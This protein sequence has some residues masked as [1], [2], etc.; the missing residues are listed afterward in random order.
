VTYFILMGIVAG[1]AI[2]EKRYRYYA[3]LPVTPSEI[4][5]VDVLYVLLVQLPMFFLW[6]LFLLL[7]PEQATSE[8][9]WA[10]LA[11]NPIILSVAT[12]VGIHYHLGFFGTPKY[13]RVNWCLL[14]LL[15]SIMV[16]LQYFGM[17]RMVARF[18]WRQ[19][20]S[21]PGFVASVLLWMGVSLLSARLFA[22]RKSYLA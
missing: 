15:V 20:T 16:E 14:V 4:A 12:I 3:T 6:I 17:G 8:S 18:L 13:K 22:R 9:I 10:M 5:L 1:Q 7:H 21:A 11:N 19:Y 2:G